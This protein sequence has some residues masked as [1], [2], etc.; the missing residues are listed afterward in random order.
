MRIAPSIIPAN[1]GPDVY[2]VVDQ[3]GRRLGRVWRETDEEDTDRLTLIH[4]LLEG[5]YND[6]VRVVAF[7]TAEGWSRDVSDDVA[8]ELRHR[9][10]DRG[11]MPAALLEF[12]ER[13]DMGRPVQLMLPI[14]AMMGKSCNS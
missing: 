4:H 11:E 1:I 2:L 6:P 13:Y 7:N 8:D 10:A 3:L 5:Q 12:L 9:C 14:G